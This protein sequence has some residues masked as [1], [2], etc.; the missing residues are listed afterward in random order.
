MEKPHVLMIG[1]HTQTL[2]QA[3]TTGVRLTVFQLPELANESQRNSCDNLVEIDYRDIPTTIAKAR[4]IHLRD[5]FDSVVSFTEYGL[6]P[7]GAIRE[8]LELEGNRL[9]P[10]QLTRDK[11]RMREHLT[12]CNF[13]RLPFRLCSSLADV[14]H[15]F[16]EVEKPIIL[17][18]AKGSGS[19]GISIATS[20][21]ELNSAWEKSF[22]AGVLPIV[23]ELFLEG[24]E[25][26]VETQ[27]LFGIHQVLAI[28]EKL[29]TERAGFVETG[30]QMPARLSSN[31]E[32]AIHH[33][34][35]GFL[36]VIGQW[37][38]PAHTEIRLTK[39]GPRIIESNTRVGGDFIFEM[40]EMT[41][42]A[43]LIAW[44]ILASVSLRYEVPAPV[45]SAAA[46]RFLTADNQRMD[47]VDGLD[48][49]EH[50]PGIRRVACTVEP[51][52]QM[53]SIRSSDDRLG[54]VL[55]FGS[56]TSEAI[57]NVQSAHAMVEFKTT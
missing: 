2:A 18:P 23:A 28:T 35:L 41:T 29:T 11:V 49:A 17:K 3:R 19:E 5:A 56:N 1:G 4:E 25:F 14:M 57:Q 48:S 24:P 34:V 40:L 46:I 10:I 54:Y 6:E 36:N 15:F 9:K 7:S 52:T 21:S 50:A 39:Q 20:E 8:E 43:E 42:G 22:S 16:A 44:T 33:Y 13:D 26:S 32:E 51:G 27:T 31:D 55:G 45:H 12:L 38:G 30:H 47:Q 53:T 37:L